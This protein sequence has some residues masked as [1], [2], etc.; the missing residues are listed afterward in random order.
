MSFEEQM[1]KTGEVEVAILQFMKDAQA[2]DP[3]I[4]DGVI[5]NA[6]ARVMGRTIA[7]GTQSPADRTKIYSNMMGVVNAAMKDED[8]R[9]NEIR[10]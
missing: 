2:T 6:L 4:I 7:V 1:K 3:Q 8:R 9:Q 5:L 10:I